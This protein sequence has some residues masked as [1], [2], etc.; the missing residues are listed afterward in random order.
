MPV[1]KSFNPKNYSTDKINFQIY[2]AKLSSFITCGLIALCSVLLFGWAGATPKNLDKYGSLYRSQGTHQ[3][4]GHFTWVKFHYAA[5]RND[6]LKI[7]KKHFFKAL[8][9]FF[10]LSSLIWLFTL[11]VFTKKHLMSNSRCPVCRNWNPGVHTAYSLHI[12]TH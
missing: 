7:Y 9:C 6:L 3:H 12:Q 2:A 1:E 8:L 10:S 11:L 5:L 4:H